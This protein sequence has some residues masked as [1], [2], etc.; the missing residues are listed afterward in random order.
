MKTTLNLCATIFLRLVS[1]LLLLLIG[2][3]LVCSLKAQSFVVSVSPSQI[4][5]STLI[6]EAG[7][8]GKIGME[9][10]NEVIHNRATKNKTLLSVCLA[11]KQ[12]SCWNNVTVE[13]GIEKAKKHPRWNLALEI[14]NSPLTNHTNGATHYHTTK[15][16]PSWKN[17]LTKT[18]QIKN[19]IFYR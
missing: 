17:S 10:V 19:H 3:L 8:E 1:R 7:G 13:S 5:A 4:V 9:A 2:A 18:T 16:S 11:P 15:V 14:A 12:F 6:L